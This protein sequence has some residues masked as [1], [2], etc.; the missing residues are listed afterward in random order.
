MSAD[1]DPVRARYLAGWAAILAEVSRTGRRLDRDEIRGRRELGERAAREGIGLRELVRGHL[2]ATRA[3]FRDLPGVAAA[4]GARQVRSAAESVLAAAEQAV[5]ALAEGYGRA[6]LLAV[7]RDEAAR[8]EFIDDLLHGRGDPGDL[9]ARALRFGLHLAHSHS[10]AVACG[11]QPY[12]DTH[13]VTRR[14]AD[15]LEGRFG[16]QLILLATK[17]GRLV[18]IAPGS[19]PEIGEYFATTARASDGTPEQ[20]RVALGRPRSGPGGIVES[21]EEARAALEL[22]ARMRLSTPVLRAA[23][24]LVFPVLTRDRQAMADLVRSV[25]GPLAGARGGAAPLVD[26]LDAYFDA[27]C[28]A[29]EAARRMSLSVRALTYRLARIHRLTGADPADPL[30]RYTLQTAVIGARLLGWP[31]QEI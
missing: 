27:G 24:L 16:G 1:E 17:D 5:D 10:V 23:E 29:A 21:Y 19:R 3:A 12:D 20:W 7:R 15:M 31:E 13:A 9:S 4:P 30:Q 18:C 25:L 2:A 8:R 28:V 14:A 6:Q 22:A 11:P 26:T